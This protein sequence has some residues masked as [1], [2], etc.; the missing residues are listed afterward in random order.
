MYGKEN[1]VD[2]Y[3]NVLGLKETSKTFT[4]ILKQE[5]YFTCCDLLHKNIISKR[6]LN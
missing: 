6:I 1:G 3:Y 4:E 5:G 2:A